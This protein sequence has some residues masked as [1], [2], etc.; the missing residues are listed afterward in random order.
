MWL[1][2]G[3]SEIARKRYLHKTTLQ[4]LERA[5]VPSIEHLD[6]AARSTGPDEGKRPTAREIRYRLM[7]PNNVSV[8]LL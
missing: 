2:F 1:A 3:F 8:T 6:A 5:V 7:C 4:R